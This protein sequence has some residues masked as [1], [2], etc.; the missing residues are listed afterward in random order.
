MDDVAR[1]PAVVRA[2]AEVQN[3]AASEVNEESGPGAEKEGDLRQLV[4]PHGL[5]YEGSPNEG[6]LCT[7]REI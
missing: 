2:A 4:M 1:P 3:A 6:P 5:P 7:V